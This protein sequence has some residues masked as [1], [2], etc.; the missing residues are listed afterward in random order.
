MATRDVLFEMRR[1]GAYVK[2][3]A[4]DAETGVEVSIVGNP[5]AGEATLKLTA[6]RKL[7]YVL[8]KKAKGE[9]ST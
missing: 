4:L 8:A 7:D 3:S 6:R 9:S 2:V 5:A 1:V